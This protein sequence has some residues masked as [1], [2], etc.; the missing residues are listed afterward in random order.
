M[1]TVE[2]ILHKKEFFNAETQ[3]EFCG[4]E[5]TLWFPV[6]PPKYKLKNLPVEKFPFI[7]TQ[8]FYRSRKKRPPNGKSQVKLQQDSPEVHQRDQEQE[9]AGEL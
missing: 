7:Y 6:P 9:E 8:Y 4:E 2:D 3:T 1:A 5:R